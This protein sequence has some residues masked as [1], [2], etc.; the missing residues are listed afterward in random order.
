MVTPTSRLGLPSNFEDGGF[1]VIALRNFTVEEENHIKERLGFDRSPGHQIELRPLHY[2]PWDA[3]TSFTEQDIY[4]IAASERERYLQAQ[5]SPGTQPR[6]HRSLIFITGS[7]ESSIATRWTSNNKRGARLDAARLPLREVAA[8]LGACEHNG[9]AISD[10]IVRYQ[11][12]RYI[13]DSGILPEAEPVPLPNITLTALCRLSTEQIDVLQSKVLS[14]RPDAVINLV[15]WDHEDVATRPDIFR[16][17]KRRHAY[18]GDRKTR[19]YEFFI[20][21]LVQDG[22]GN[23]QVLIA[24]QDILPDNRSFNPEYYKNEE[25][26]LRR[27]ATT[28]VVPAWV[29]LIMNPHDWAEK[30]FVKQSY[31]EYIPNPDQPLDFDE[32]NFA[33]PVL[34]L[35]RFTVDEER[36]VRAALDDL[37]DFEDDAS[38]RRTFFVQ[39]A[40]EEDMSPRDLVQT[41][42]KDSA[43]TPSEG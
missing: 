8:T 33:A 40:T 27:I 22:D 28:S 37:S 10:Q 38:A 26:L 24:R 13:F 7:D 15:Q 31:T 29:N 30:D 20:D 11:A 6:W 5:D 12:V 25:V 9:V 3:S 2:I 43:E 42:D 36:R 16:I 4:A 32:D 39:L 23:H 19:F 14:E 35:C 18:L 17:C 41:F 21:G 34:F 1:A